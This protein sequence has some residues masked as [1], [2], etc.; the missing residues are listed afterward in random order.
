MISAPYNVVIIDDEETMAEV[1]EIKLDEHFGDK[2]NTKVFHKPGDE[3]MDYIKD[4]KVQIVLTDIHL[5]GYYGDSYCEQYRAINKNMQIIVVSGD[6]TFTTVS[7]C[8]LDGA[9]FYLKKP[10]QFDQLIDAMENC[11]FRL[12][13]WSGYF[14]RGKK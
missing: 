14:N 11:I 10:F 5:A 12:D 2:I 4:N 8:Y 13:T 6:A 9:A 1:Y 7:N 3:V